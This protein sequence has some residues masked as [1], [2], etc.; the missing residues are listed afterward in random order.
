LR[1]V[2]VTLE[3]AARAPAKMPKEWLDFRTAGN[4]ASFVDTAYSEERLVA[5]VTAAFGS[6][7]EIDAQPIGLRSIFKTLAR[8]TR[9][10]SAA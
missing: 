4:V 2:H 10:G 7:R 5:S 8:A 1:E 6:V 3:S 9:D